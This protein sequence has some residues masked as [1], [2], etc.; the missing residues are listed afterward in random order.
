M[1]KPIPLNLPAYPLKLTRNQEKVLVFDVLRKKNLILTPE[2]WVRQHWIHYLHQHKKYPKALMKIEGGLQLNS[3]Q[4]RSDLLIYNRK[5]NMVLL[6]EFKAPHVKITQN[7]FHQIAN[8]NSIHKIPLL[9]VSNG[10]EHY[11]CKID[12]EKETFEF[13]EELPNY[14]E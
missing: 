11:Y 3:L 14:I 7:T 10:L 4:K 6:A 12:F 13:I 5:G 2:E 8:Y 9:L 1:F